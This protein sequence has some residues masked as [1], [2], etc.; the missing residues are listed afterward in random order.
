MARL[1]KGQFFLLGAILLVIM[2]LV[3]L[4][5]L[6]PPSTLPS[7]DLSYFAENIKID[8]PLSLSL[9]IKAGSVIESLENFTEF[10]D[11]ILT[12]R[13]VNFSTLWVVTEPGYNTAL[14]LSVGN[15]LDNEEEVNVTI[16]DAT[17]IAN[18]QGF[19]VLGDKCGN[20]F[21]GQKENCLNCPQDCSCG[22]GPDGGNCGDGTKQGNEQCDDGNTVS[23]DGC[24]S[25]CKSEYCGNDACDT[26]ETCIT[27]P[28]DCGNCKELCG[29]DTCSNGELCSICPAD[30]G[31]CPPVNITFIIEPGTFNMTTF[32]PISSRMLVQIMWGSEYREYIWIREKVN[33][34]SHITLEKR[35]DIISQD[36]VR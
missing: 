9:G 7:Q 3:G 29:D 34:Y 27:C 5:A 11:T 21:C 23:G 28:G 4:T 12:N 6:R 15:F 32:F 14:N 33:F 1:V 30:C 18:F 19:P 2:F 36:I 10:T 35:D 25:S 16:S 17:L 24:S 31:L 13:L 26:G 22:G 20:G 8:M